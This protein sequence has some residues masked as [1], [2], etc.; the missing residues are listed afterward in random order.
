MFLH[1]VYIINSWGREEGKHDHILILEGFYNHL[2][3]T[4]TPY[5]YPISVTFMFGARPGVCYGSVARESLTVVSSQH[6]TCNVAIFFL[7][8]LMLNVFGFFVRIFCLTPFRRYFGY[9]ATSTSF[10][11]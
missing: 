8:L 1:F 5:I 4:G 11:P 7:G 9:V 10:S 3:P 6:S 2:Y